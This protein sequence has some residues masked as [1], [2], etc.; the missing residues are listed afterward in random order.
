MSSPLNLLT[1]RVD[2]LSAYENHQLPWQVMS[3]LSLF[4]QS[5]LQISMQL[6][7]FSFSGTQNSILNCAMSPISRIGASRLHLMAARETTLRIVRIKR[8]DCERCIVSTSQLLPAQV[9]EAQKTT[10]RAGRSIQASFPAARKSPSGLGCS[11]TP[12]QGS[13]RPLRSTSA[14]LR[15]P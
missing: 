5:V 2:A 1:Q 6:S 12:S 14:A 3:C 15:R 10:S 7:F 4:C 9:K 8:N 11:A 13:G